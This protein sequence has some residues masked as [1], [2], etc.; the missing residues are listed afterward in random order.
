M[1]MIIRIDLACRKHT[2]VFV[3]VKHT[4]LLIEENETGKKRRKTQTKVCRR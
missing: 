2:N 4:H 1:N 3:I